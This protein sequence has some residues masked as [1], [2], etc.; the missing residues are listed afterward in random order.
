MIVA[1]ESV[2]GAPPDVL[3]TA[4]PKPLTQ[5]GLIARVADFLLQ[6][7]VVSRLIELTY[8]LAETSY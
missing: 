6:L 2:P 1:E 7:S 8:V 3:A 4:D 5:L